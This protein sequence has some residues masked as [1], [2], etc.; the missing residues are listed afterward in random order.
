MEG[1]VY[2]GNGVFSST[3]SIKNDILGPGTQILNLVAVDYN[4]DSVNDLVYSYINGGQTIIVLQPI[5]GPNPASQQSI[6]L[7]SNVSVAANGIAAADLNQDGHLDLVMLTTSGA[8]SQATYWPGDGVSFAPSFTGATALP[9][10]GPQALIL[11]DIS[12]DGI[13]DYIIGNYAMHGGT[14]TGVDP[15]LLSTYLVAAKSV[16]VGAPSISVDGGQQRA[17]P[18]NVAVGVADFNRNGLTDIGICWTK[19]TDTGPAQMLFSH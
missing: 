19:A 6:F 5:V 9:L 11:A 1:H 2:Q 14:T 12:N 7:T 8:T 4:T 3:A 17:V 15:R 16:P 13:P 10:N 18:D